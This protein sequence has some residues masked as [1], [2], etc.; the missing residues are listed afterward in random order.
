MKT[1]QFITLSLYS[2]LLLGSIASLRA[3]DPWDDSP[4]PRKRLVRLD[5]SWKFAVGDGPERAAPN[6]DDSGWANIH[7]SETWQDEGYRDYNGYA[8]Y[9]QSFSLPSGFEQNNVFLALGKIDDV[10][11]VFV[12]GRRVGGTGKFPP[13]YQSAY[14]N[15]R[16]YPVPAAWLRPGK[17]NVIAIRVYD[18]GGVGGLVSGRPGFYTGITP[19][20]EIVLDGPWKFS[21]GDNADWKKP[22][23]D[24]S[25][26][27]SI[28]VPLAW[29][30][31]GYP[32]LDG[33][34]WYRKTFTIDR[35]PT[36]QTM[37]LMLGKI[38][39]YDEVF[40]NGTSIGRTGEIDRPGR[41]DDGHSYAL[42]RA[43]YFPSS[44]L[45]ENNTLAVRVYDAG[46]YGGIYAGP[47]GIVSQTEFVNY[48]EARRHH[49]MRDLLHLF[50]LDE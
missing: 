16:I 7:S 12:N 2:A 13:N 31:A 28:T 43:Y 33:Y 49:P 48:W 9:R 32:D 4:E 35:T 23:F 25:D 42:N 19:Q 6:Y 27:K 15:E 8:W 24:D 38:D 1:H 40:L 36:D 29:E 34:A 20:T 3:Y 18:G 11:E 47:V 41:H 21:P 10:D 39:D 5:R 44:L 45:K 37:V 17:S 30:N 46:G 14:D 50:G 22:A 26:F